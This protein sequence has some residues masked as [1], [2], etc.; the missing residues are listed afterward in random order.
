MLVLPPQPLRLLVVQP[1]IPVGLPSQILERRPNILQAERILTSA[2]AHI[3]EAR[4]YFFPTLAIT[5]QGGLQ[6]VQLGNWLNGGS[7]AYLDP[8]G[9]RT[10]NKSRLEDELDNFDWDQYRFPEC[11]VIYVD[12]CLGILCRSENRGPSLMRRNEPG[13]DSQPTRGVVPYRLW[14]IH[15]REPLRQPPL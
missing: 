8:T 7:R 15:P 1:D 14:Q 9:G 10:Y 6:S 5:G 13:P 11:C 12:A 4:A 2:N 3:G